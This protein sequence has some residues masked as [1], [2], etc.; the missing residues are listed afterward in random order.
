MISSAIQRGAVVHIY[1]EYNRQTGTVLARETD[2]RDG[3]LGY[4]PSQISVRRGLYVYQ[5]GERGEHLA[6]VLAW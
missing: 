2:S 4:T 3:L 6:T 5:Y 1:D